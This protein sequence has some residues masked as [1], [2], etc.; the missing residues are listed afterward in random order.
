MSQKSDKLIDYEKVAA[1][2]EED[3]HNVVE[4]LEILKNEQLNIENKISRNVPEGL[5]FNFQ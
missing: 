1:E 3:S 4:E 2:G 5:K